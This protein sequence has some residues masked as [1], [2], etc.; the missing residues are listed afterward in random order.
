MP[1]SVELKKKKKCRQSPYPENK[2]KKVTNGTRILRNPIVRN[3]RRSN[4]SDQNKE[5]IPCDPRSPLGRGGL[6]RRLIKTGHKSMGF[7][8]PRRSVVVA[9]ALGN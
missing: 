7:E 6:G 5:E 1:Y 4:F 2:A 9:I 3:R 8:V